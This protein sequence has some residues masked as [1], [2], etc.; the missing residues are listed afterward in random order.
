M[1]T[2]YRAPVGA[3][4]WIDLST[5]D[6]DRAS[7]FYGAVFGWTFERPGP[8]Y[9]GYVNAFVGGSPVAG[10]MPN[11]PQWD[12]PDGWSVYL[13]VDDVDAALERVVA[14]GGASCGGAMDV[15][16]K[17]RMAMVGDPAGAVVGLWQPA[18]HHGFEVVGDA[19]AP[20]WHQLTT[21]DYARALDFYRAVFDWQLKVEADADDFRYTNALFAGEP[22]LGVMDGAVLPD[23]P[24]TWTTFLG[25]EDVDAT[26]DVVVRHGGTVVRGAEDTPYGRLAA[27]TDPT[28]AA[29][30]L[31]SLAG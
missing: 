3:P 30:N 31:A 6:L 13:H 1:T 26:L 10:L 20:V 27:A 11:D 21:R 12:M 4:T 15:P 28:G 8:G 24:S 2:G 19:G 18:G 16:A 9:G 23:G 14:N 17:G 29:F 5:S 22:L 7:E 25:A